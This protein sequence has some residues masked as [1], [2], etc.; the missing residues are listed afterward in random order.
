MEYRIYRSHQSLS[1]NS[2]GNPCSHSV[3]DLLCYVADMPTRSRLCS[4][5]SRPLYTSALDNSSLS[6][7]AHSLMADHGS[8]DS[9]HED[10]QSASSLKTFR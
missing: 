2:P 1:A 5:T 4:F 9:L 6:V 3:F 10:Y 7:T 8:A